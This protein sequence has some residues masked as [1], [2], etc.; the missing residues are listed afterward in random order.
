MRDLIDKLQLLS[1]DAKAIEQPDATQNA[2]PQTTA[3]QAPEPV[4]KSTYAP[5]NLMKE[6]EQNLQTDFPEYRF[7]TEKKSNSP[8]IYIR[9]FGPTRQEAVDYFKKQGFNTIPPT[10]EQSIIS[11]KYKSNILS[12]DVNGTIYTIVIAG[13][14]NKT[15]NPETNVNIKE[16][17]PVALGLT[18]Q[19][20]N[21]QSLIKATRA[22]IEAKCAKRPVLKEIMLQLVDVANGSR[23]AVDPELNE[24]LG[25]K[26]RNQLGVDFGEI[27]A[28]IKL[29]KSGDT[30]EFPAEGNFPLIDVVIGNNHYSV[31]SLT[32][33]GTSFK[34]IADL[35]DS[36]EMAIDRDE[37][38]KDLYSMFKGFHPKSG[39]KNVDKII[40]AAAY[41]KTPE[42]EKAVEI[43]GNFDDYSSLQNA[44]RDLLSLA[45]NKTMQYSDFLRNVLPIMTAGGW[46]KPVGM[47]ADGNFYLNPTGSKKPAEKTA[48]YPSYRAKP[49]KSAT[50][51]LTYSLGVG[52]LNAVTKGPNSEA[53]SSMMT[54]I[55]NQSQAWLGK[56]DITPDGEVMASAAP[57]SKLKFNFQYHAPSHIPGN[58]LPGFMIVY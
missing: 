41:M 1:E 19:T 34:S 25:D 18:G 49:V 44:V 29:A 39:G 20:Y 30:I 55:V 58:N 10:P 40:R 11:G 23:N 4:A 46:D 6:L 28:P 42:Y 3:P 38:K 27:L 45:G 47:P 36:Y 5:R 54:D 16:F 15:G 33:S 26:S 13:Q 14:N 12:F 52:L 21:K 31:K 53:Y 17:T 43:L 35:M 50:D 48:G 2:V 8:V 7:K 37:Y 56:L 24:Q 32:G 9:A 57:F 22:A 51:I